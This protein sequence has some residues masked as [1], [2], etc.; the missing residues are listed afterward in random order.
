M[1]NLIGIIGLLLAAP[2]LATLKLLG[3]YTLRKMLDLDPWH[4]KPPPPKT[5]AST[6]R[7]RLWRR[8]QAWV[9]AFKQR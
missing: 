4:E 5:A 2:V 8:L 7:A 9:R 6:P 3:T 1:A